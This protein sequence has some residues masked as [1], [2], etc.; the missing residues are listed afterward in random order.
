[1][2]MYKRS[3]YLG[4]LVIPV[5]KY[6]DGLHPILMYKMSLY[7]ETVVPT[8]IYKERLYLILMY[9]FIFQIGVV[10]P[11]PKYKQLCIQY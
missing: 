7:F 3:L 6:N 9:S 5:P 10:V 11:V 1:M 2:L 8:P 4:I